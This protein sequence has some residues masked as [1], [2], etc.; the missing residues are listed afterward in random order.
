LRTE[1]ADFFYN[2]FK[3]KTKKEVY[4]KPHL[5]LLFVITQICVAVAHTALEQIRQI[6]YLIE[7]IDC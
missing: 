7:L 6:V 1:F 4:F 5:F 3:L 2:F